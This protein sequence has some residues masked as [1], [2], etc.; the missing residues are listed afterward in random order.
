MR[1][2]WLVLGLATFTLSAAT[3]LACGEPFILDTSAVGA[4]GSTG[5]GGMAS[6]GSTGSTGSTGGQSS[7]E[8]DSDCPGPSGG[9][10]HQTCENKVCVTKYVPANEESTSKLYGDCRV[11]KCD[12]KGNAQE[13]EI[14]PADVYD[15]ANTCTNDICKDGKP[16]QEMKL[17]TACDLPASEGLCNG[18]GACVQCLNDMNCTSPFLC[19]QARCAPI[20]CKSAKKDADETD[21]DC[22]GSCGPCDDLKSCTLTSDCKSRVCTGAVNG[23]KCQIPSCGDSVLNGDETDID[24]GGSA[25]VEQG[26]PCKDTQKCRLATDCESGVCKAGLCEA[27]SCNDGVQ[28]GGEMGIDCGGPCGQCG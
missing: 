27:S 1:A 20:T 18:A 5:M 15:D 11:V 23:K 19:I 8:Q 25:C 13:P 21:V 2:G 22:G 9:C 7:C 6:S 4:S 14:D 16:T 26:A 28:N 10:V 3:P 12:G 24:C 17:N